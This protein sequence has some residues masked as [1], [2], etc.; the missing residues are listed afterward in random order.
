MARIE[1]PPGEGKEADRMWQ[2]APHMG[3]GLRAMSVAVYEQSTLS[4]REREVARYRIAQLNECNVCLNTR[5]KGAIERG[6]TDEL[7]QRIA[8]YVELPELTPRE[9]LAAEFA[10]Q[11]AIDHTQIGDE[12]FERLR[13]HYSD[14]E[15]LELAVTAGFCVGMGRAFHVLDVARDFDVLWSRQPPPERIH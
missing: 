7:Y 11:F 8:Q 10:E 6:L 12:L 14:A 9:R 13:E 1:V 4:I 3:A 2:L 5:A 15:I